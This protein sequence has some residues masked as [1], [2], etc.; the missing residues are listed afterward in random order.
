MGTSTAAPDTRSAWCTA[1]IAR[2]PKIR[3]T[4]NHRIEIHPFIAKPMPVQPL[5]FD[6]PGEATANGE[7]TLSWSREPG[8]GGNGRGCQVSRNLVNPKMSDTSWESP[9][10]RRL[11]EGRPVIAA[12]ITSA[13]LEA[14]AHMAQLGFDFLWIEM[15]HSPIT[16]ETLRGMVL[17]TRGSPALAF[18]RVPVNEIWMAKRVLDMGVSGVIF[19]F[20]RYARAGTASRGGVLLS[21]GRDAA[22]REPFPA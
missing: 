10:K 19:P 4:A 11:R 3:L 1:A 20:T 12:T 8:L 18:A 5:E 2:A 17:A 15:E 7:L 21:T 13:S 9:V 16:L 14:A 6:I 22:A